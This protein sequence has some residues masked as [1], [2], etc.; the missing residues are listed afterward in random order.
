MQPRSAMPAPDTICYRQAVADDASQI[1]T[2]ILDSQHE[3]TFHE[4]TPAGQELM[5]KLCS[6]RAIREYIERGDIYFVAEI[7]GAIIGV[8]GIRQTSHVAHNFVATSWHRKGISG[9]LWKL[10]RA[11]CLAA[12][13]R[14]EFDLRASTFAIPVYEKW[15]FVITG[16]AED[17]GGIISTPMRLENC[18]S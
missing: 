2:L 5:Q 1:S 15:G 18:D 6:G 3:F 9:Q 8:I 14:G 11:A 4:Y 10:G 17:T 12:G 16:E 7:D 13:N